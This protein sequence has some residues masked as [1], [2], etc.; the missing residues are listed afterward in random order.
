LGKAISFLE[1]ELKIN[2]QNIGLR[3]VIERLKK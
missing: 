3:E 2:P 1:S